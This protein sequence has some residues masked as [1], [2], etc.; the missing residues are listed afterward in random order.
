MVIVRRRRSTLRINLFVAHLSIPVDTTELT[1]LQPRRG[2]VVGRIAGSH[3]IYIIY[4]FSIEI[5]GIG[6]RGRNTAQ[7]QSCEEGSLLADRGS[8]FRAQEVSD[9]GR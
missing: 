3:F 4:I 8:L 2:Y 7:S 1:S 5:D 6:K 9:F